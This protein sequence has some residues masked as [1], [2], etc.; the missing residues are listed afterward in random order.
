MISNPP[1]RTTHQKNWF[2]KQLSIHA[3][4][5]L[6]LFWSLKDRSLTLANTWL[7]QLFNDTTSNVILCPIYLQFSLGS[8]FHAKTLATTTWNRFSFWIIPIMHIG[9]IGSPSY[10]VHTMFQNSFWILGITN[11]IVDWAKH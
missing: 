3:I 9:R 10:I 4:G 2:S 7:R 5:S 6:T 11:T 1:P 8:C